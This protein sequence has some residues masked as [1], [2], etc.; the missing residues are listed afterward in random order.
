[1][2][3]HA[4]MSTFVVGHQRIILTG[5]LPIIPVVWSWNLGQNPYAVYHWYLCQISKWSKF[6]ILGKLEWTITTLEFKSSNILM[7]KLNFI[8]KKKKKYVI[9]S[10]GVK[11]CIT[12]TSFTWYECISNCIIQ[13]I[14][15]CN[16]L[17]MAYI[18]GIV[19][20][21]P[22]SGTDSWSHLQR[23]IYW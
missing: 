2:R 10:Q 7:M 8:K 3:K 5:V 14:L 6:T 20:S 11:A 19:T 4:F 12:Y 13:D 17:S 16:Y 22:F 23:C 9:L 15:G 1:M 21:V 18:P